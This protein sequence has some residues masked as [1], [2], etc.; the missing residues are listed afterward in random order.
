VTGWQQ[1][2]RYPD[3]AVRILDE[4]FRQYVVVLAKVERLATGCRWSEGP[5]WFGDQRCLIWSDIPGDRL[6]RWDELT[7]ESAVFRHPAQFANGN[8]RDRQG[9]LVTCEHGERRVVRTEYDGTMTVVADSYEGRP[10][11]SPNDVIVASNGA[12]WFTDPAFGISGDYEGHRA[13]AELPTNVYRVDADSLEITCAADDI[14]S[15]NGLAFSPD[16]KLLYVVQSRGVPRRNIVVYDV[17]D[18]FP[19]NQR[20]LI[21]AEDGIP[22]GLCVDED[23]NLWCGW[24]MGTP[25]LDGVRVFDPEGVLLGHIALPERCAN[26]TFGGRFRNRLF[27]AA[28]S[29][30]YA[31][32][33]NTRGAL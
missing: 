26:V 11:N 6:M 20:V 23:G 27:M 3:P 28:G 12:V 5:V 30:L 7:G 1:A 15:P 4:R 32:Y 2:V 25:E 19:A 14:R 31:L 33:V 9:R 10:L 16:E 18:G 24:G 8:A 13:Q 22:D 21:D 29:S 17:V